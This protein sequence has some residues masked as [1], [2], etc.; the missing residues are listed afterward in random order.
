LFENVG[1]EP[2][3]QALRRLNDFSTVAICGLI[4]SYDEGE[5]TGLP[6]M[7]VFLAKRIRME[8]FI[9]SDHSDLWPEAI[10]EL[11]GLIAA[12]RLTWRETIRNGLE[13]APQG[14][15]DLLHGRNLGK[16][17]IRVS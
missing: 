4:S 2:F 5:P 15:I 7:R 8:G 14:L 10:G 17:L 3:R 13:Q 6:D 9:I 12:K 1:G 11:A 16:M